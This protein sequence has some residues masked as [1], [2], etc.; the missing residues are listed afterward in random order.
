MTDRRKE[1]NTT[2]STGNQKIGMKTLNVSLSPVASCPKGVPC[3]KDCYAIK[4]YRMYPST[5]AAW[6]R[7]LEAARADVHGFHASIRDQIAS[8]RTA[9]AFFRWHVAGDIISRE[10]LEEM[11][12]TAQ[13]FPKTRFLAFTKAHDIVNSCD[14]AMPD[15]LT[16]VFSAWPGRPLDNPRGL[17]VAWMQDGTETRVPESAVECP[18]LCDGCGM[19]WQLPK[20]GRD[21]VFNKH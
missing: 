18:G 12:K 1:M 9:P 7:N 11:V 4:A 20:L 16:V 17:P 10:Y 13:A 15:N 6:D 19:C 21:V 8:K 5:K 3:A 2:L 14:V